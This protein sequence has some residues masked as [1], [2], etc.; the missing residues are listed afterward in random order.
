MKSK[1]TSKQDD[2]HGRLREQDI[3]DEEDAL[4]RLYKQQREL[5]HLVLDKEEKVREDLRQIESVWSHEEGKPMTIWAIPEEVL[6]PADQF[7]K[8]RLID[9]MDQGEVLYHN[10]EL[11]RRKAQFLETSLPEDKLVDEMFSV[12]LE[13]LQR[14]EA[15]TTPQ[16]KKPRAKSEAWMRK[17][18]VQAVAETN[19]GTKGKNLDLLTCVELDGSRIHVLERWRL[20]HGIQTWEQG[21]EHPEVKQLIQTMFSKDRK[22]K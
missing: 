7:S 9:L 2:P 4:I 16:P 3:S 18:M 22:L 13:E 17:R 6:S 14:R 10:L 20:T 19:P 8:S 11:I 12:S 5:L 21:Y 1:Q 15:P